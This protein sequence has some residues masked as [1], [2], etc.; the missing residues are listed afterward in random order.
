M[1]EK[2]CRQCRYCGYTN[3]LG[4]TC[5]Y[6]LIVGHS[7]TA[8]LTKEEKAGPCREFATGRRIR[9]REGIVY[10]VKS[11]YAFD[12]QKIRKLYFEGLNDAEIARAIGSTKTPV[13]QWRQRHNL[14]PNA[15]RGFPGKGDKIGKRDDVH[16]LR[17]QDPVDPGA[18]GQADP[19]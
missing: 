3:T 7:R 11:H 5:D 4:W 12:Q 18:G 15:P 8:G 9:R 2:R 13:R 10:S 1:K 16:V 19:H 14:G 6:L 17:S